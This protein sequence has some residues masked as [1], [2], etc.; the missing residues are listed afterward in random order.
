MY[1]E[2]I[3]NFDR[4]MELVSTWTQRSLLFKDIV[5]S[6]QVGQPC[7]GLRGT[8]LGSCSTWRKSGTL[9]DVSGCPIDA[10]ILKITPRDRSFYFTDGRVMAQRGCAI[11]AIM[12]CHMIEPRSRCRPLPPQCPSVAGA[13]TPDNA[14]FVFSFSFS[15]NSLLLSPAMVVSFLL[16]NQVF[17]C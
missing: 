2:Y 4:A 11:C 12:N 1:G 5:H 15:A 10:L 14:T 6:I 9:W 16:I 8:A 7:H 17:I 13:G 3:K